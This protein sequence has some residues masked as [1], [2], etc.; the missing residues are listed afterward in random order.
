MICL[1]ID[2]SNYTTSA[3]LYDDATGDVIQKRR[4]L[5]VKPG[6]LG[7]R[8]SDAVFQHTLALPELLKELLAG[9]GKTP[10]V[11]AVSTAPR[12]EEG[13]Y[14]PC[15]MVGKGTADSLGA[16]FSRPVGYFSHQAGHIAAA[17]YSAGRLDWLK[18]EFLAF[19]VSG[20]TTEAVRVSPDAQTLLRTEL[21]ARSLDLKAG[22]AIDRVGV[23]LGLAFPAGPAL[24]ELS[25]QS[26]KQ[27]KI[28]PFLRDG[29]CSLSGLQNR[30]EQMKQAGE[31]DCD[32]ARYC[33]EYICAALRG[34]TRKLTETHPGLPV[35]Y[36]GGVMSNSLIRERFTK[37]FG[38][39][40]AAPGFS[41]DNAVGVAVLGAMRRRTE[42]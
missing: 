37:E 16:V 1:G 8:Q 29:D 22:Q 40:F 38:A 14:M 13:S 39:V 24:D 33:M 9:A 3:A 32:I 42:R 17:L 35:L 10:D 6:E 12:G 20:G 7:L 21:V 2:T 5:K 27:Y 28:K 11:I 23:M 36:S 4:L 34:M 31:A 19:H 41:S 26:D 30:C 18:K 15:F 25:R